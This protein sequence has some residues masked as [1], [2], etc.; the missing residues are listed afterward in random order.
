MGKCV[1]QFSLCFSSMVSFWRVTSITFSNAQQK[2]KL[3]EAGEAMTDSVFHLIVKFLKTLNQSNFFRM[4]DP[5]T[6]QMWY[7][8]NSY[9]IVFIFFRRINEVEERNQGR[10]QGGCPRCP[11]TPL[12]QKIP[13]GGYRA[14]KLFARAKNFSRWWAPP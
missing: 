4:N 10:S 6:Y 11:G 7:T 2:S 8:N 14:E 1:C 3:T 5:K 9:F 12:G 13:G